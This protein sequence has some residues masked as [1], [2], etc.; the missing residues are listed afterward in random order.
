[1]E[2]YQVKAGDAL[3][4]IAQDVLG[5]V[6]AWSKLAQLNNIVAPYTI[7]P[8]QQLMLPDLSVL[9]PIVVQAKGPPLPTGEP[10]P[11]KAGFDLSPQMMLYLALGAVALFI[12]TDRK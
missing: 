11:I 8:G 7:F 3:R 2:F 10:P 12:F 6:A 5:D 1:M 9:G 4:T